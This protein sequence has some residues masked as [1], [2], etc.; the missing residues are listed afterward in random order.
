MKNIF[1]KNKKNDSLAELEKALDEYKDSALGCLQYI[2]PIDAAEVM[3]EY[4][5]S[6]HCSDLCRDRVLLS[7]THDNNL[8]ECLEKIESQREVGIK[9]I[10]EIA[11]LEE[12]IKSL[13][14]K[15]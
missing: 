8:K 2:H 3:I 1:K 13:K 4:L 14:E 9:R 5:N 12:E 10:R 15:G 6:C 11:K 7:L